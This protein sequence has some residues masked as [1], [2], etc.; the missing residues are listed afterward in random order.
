[1][2]LD[3]IIIFM[4]NLKVSAPLSFLIHSY[5]DYYTIHYIVINYLL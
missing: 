2:Y 3:Q 5:S 1:M 4:I